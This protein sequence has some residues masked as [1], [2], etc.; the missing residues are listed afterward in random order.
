MGPIL[1]GST[2]TLLAVLLLLASTVAVWWGARDLVRGLR[3]AAQPAGSLWLVRG[4]RGGIVSVTLGALA[5][6]L[7]T[8]QMWLLIFG[9][10]FLGEELYETG[11][12]ILVLRTGEE[13]LGRRRGSG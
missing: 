13:G 2:G 4:L 7:L 5:G 6:G 11:V 12:L 9:A 1:T 10:I 8:G 3:E